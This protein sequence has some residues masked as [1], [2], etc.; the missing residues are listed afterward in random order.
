MTRIRM[1]QRPR[2]FKTRCEAPGCGKVV[3]N[4]VHGRGACGNATIRNLITDCSNES[5][6]IVADAVSAGNLEQC[7]LLVNAGNK[8]GTKRE[9]FTIPDWALPGAPGRRGFPD[10]PDIVVIKNWRRGT[11][12]PTNARQTPGYTG[13]VVTFLIAEHK[14]SND[15]YLKEGCNEKRSIYV[16]LV[17]A[18]LQAGWAVELNGKVRDHTTWYGQSPDYGAPHRAQPA[19]RAPVD[20]AEHDDSDAE[21]TDSEDDRPRGDNHDDADAGPL[22]LDSQRR[23]APVLTPAKLI[24]VEE[25][26]LR[27]PITHHHRWTD[28]YTPQIQ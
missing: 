20:A 24:P 15:F 21:S 4:L 10:K 28:L 5:V 25:G 19:T 12:P 18:L 2:N 7:A 26:E 3:L 11:P 13:P 6:H 22:R 9:D 8:Y 1:N 16:E 27:L 23:Q 17:L 14:L